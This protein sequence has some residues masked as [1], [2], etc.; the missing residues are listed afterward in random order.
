[1]PIERFSTTWKSSKI[2]ADSKVKVILLMKKIYIMISR[3]FGGLIKS[4][5]T[6]SGIRPKTSVK[7]MQGEIDDCLH[8]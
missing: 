7:E 8:C 4:I 5:E 1:M 3:L 2:F 6:W